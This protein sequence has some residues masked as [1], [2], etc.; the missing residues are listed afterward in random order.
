ME[1]F[2]SEGKEHAWVAVHQALRLLLPRS[3]SASQFQGKEDA[4][5]IETRNVDALRQVKLLA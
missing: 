1:L 5:E 4:W 3:E 2:R